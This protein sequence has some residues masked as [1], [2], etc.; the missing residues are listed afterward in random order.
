MLVGAKLLVGAKFGDKLIKM[1]VFLNE[2]TPSI[3]YTLTHHEGAIDRRHLVLALVVAGTAG[4][5]GVEIKHLLRDV[6]ALFRVSGAQEGDVTAGV[7]VGRWSQGKTKYVH[8]VSFCDAAG[9][10][11]CHGVVGDKVLRQAR[12]G[13]VH[14]FASLGGAMN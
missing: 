8:A 13:Y 11:L 5:A 14:S 2:A 12:V 6:G 7:E 3:M 9:V 10:Y 1:P 4:V